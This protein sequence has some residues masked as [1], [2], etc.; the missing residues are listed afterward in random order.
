LILLR[1]II[2]FRS[3]DLYEQK[4]A[5]ELDIKVIDSQILKPE[6]KLEQNTVLNNLLVSIKKAESNKD[7]K[8]IRNYRQPLDFGLMR[9]ILFKWLQ[10]SRMQPIIHLKRS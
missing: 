7:P 3:K 2:L 5:Q 4:K 9:P 8:E 6:K 1:R 10:L